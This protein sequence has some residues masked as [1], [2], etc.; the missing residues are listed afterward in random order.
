MAEIAISEMQEGSQEEL[1][2]AVFAAEVPGDPGDARK[3]A[4]LAFEQYLR[5]LDG[6]RGIILWAANKSIDANRIIFDANRLWLSIAPDDGT[7]GSPS[8]G[9]ANFLNIYPSTVTVGANFPPNPYTNDLRLF[10]TA[11]T[12][13]TGAVDTDGT[14]AKTSAQV[15]DLFRYNGT[16]W[17]YISFIG[18]DGVLTRLYLQSDD[19]LIAERS[20]GATLHTSLAHLRHVRLINVT[21]DAGADNYTTETIANHTESYGDN[22]QYEFRAIA[23]NVGAV[24][25]RV[26]Y[27]VG[28]QLLYLGYRTVLDIH[29]LQLM[30]G[31]MQQGELIAVRYDTTIGAWISNIY[32]IADATHPGL[33]SSAQ[34]GKL[35]SA[36]PAFDSLPDASTY[37]VGQV[38][39]VGRRLYKSYNTPD[40]NVIAGTIDVLTGSGFSIRGTRT[41]DNEYGSMGQWTSNPNRVVEWLVVDSTNHIEIAIEQGAYRTAKGSN[42]VDGDQLTLEIT[43]GETTQSAVVSL[44]SGSVDVSDGLT[45]LVFDGTVAADFV[46][47]AADQGDGFELLI[48]QGGSLFVVHDANVRH[49]NVY[50]LS[51][52]LR[53]PST[54]PQRIHT[55][56]RT[57]TDADGNDDDIWIN[58]QNDERA[59]IWEKIE[60]TWLRLTGATK[61]TNEQ[62]RDLVAGFLT[63]GTNVTITHDDANNT[64]TIAATASGGTGGLTAE[65][66]RDLVAGFITAGTNVTVTHDDPS[67]TFTI[68]LDSPQLPALPDAGS[69]DNKIPKFD[70]D[71]LGWEE[72]A[73]ASGG[74][75]TA[76]APYAIMSINAGTTVGAESATPI[77]VPFALSAAR[78]H[79]ATGIIARDTAQATQIVLEPGTYEI[80]NHIIVD[81]TA[82]ATSNPRSNYTVQLYDG[83]TVLDEKDSIGYV[84]AIADVDNESFDSHH[85]L[86]LTAQTSIQ[87]RIGVSEAG[88]TFTSA[89]TATGGTV[90]IR[91]IGSAVPLQL[92]GVKNAQTEDPTGSL[93]FGADFNGNAYVSEIKR[94]EGTPAEGAWTQ[95]THTNYLGAYARFPYLQAPASGRGKYF[96]SKN[97]H[98]FYVSASSGYL[99]YITWNDADVTDVFGNSAI[100]LGEFS[101]EAD[102][103]RAVKNFS[104]SN[105]YYAYF[106]DHVRVLTNAGYT[107]SVSPTETYV[108][109]RV[110]AEE[111]KQLAEVELKLDA[112]IDSFLKGPSSPIVT[113]NEIEFVTE[114]SDPTA[115]STHNYEY[116]TI[117]N[118]G[119]IPGLYRR[120]TIADN[121]TLRFKVGHNGDS[122]GFS[123]G[124]LLGNEYPDFGTVLANIGGSPIAAY[125]WLNTETFG[126]VTGMLIKESAMDALITRILAARFA[127]GDTYVTQNIYSNGALPDDYD[128]S[129]IHGIYLGGVT[130]RLT[131]PDGTS[132]S[133]DLIYSGITEEIDGHRFRMYYRVGGSDFFASH[134]SDDYV[135]IRIRSD[136][137]VE[138]QF[139]GGIGINVGTG[140]DLITGTKGWTG[141]DL[142]HPTSRAMAGGLFTLQQ[143]AVRSDSVHNI[144]VLTQAEYTALAT[145]DAGTVYMIVG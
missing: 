69:R 95:A 38:V 143:K 110:G 5:T 124:N 76:D 117:E 32:P 9:N 54:E 137:D 45:Y 20:V 134:A 99:D 55:E 8:S 85:I 64:L 14:T 52:D 86:T 39:I 131:E 44:V 107:A 4:I 1:E 135:D 87:V 23:T 70:G 27:T 72:D 112:H 140:L 128:F 94:T 36:V 88:A 142:Y 97:H 67:N 59:E 116:L 100:W 127:A 25:L 33:M 57:P 63:A 82:A 37:P 56:S 108:W 83:T 80:T 58:V 101:T 130:V 73:G 126:R 129:G 18:S 139:Q 122:W 77:A 98:D 133:V 121:N 60:G 92:S 103:L 49:W 113:Q 79:N 29:G 62:I 26:S 71:I 41:G 21:A 66:V 75:P 2:T 65:Q 31:A 144:V 111:S 132:A 24:H 28:G 114:L 34:F 105:A 84:R 53:E 7:N 78:S 30:P 136:V 96:Y 51:G 50:S 118:G 93:Q 22:D 13:L 19:T 91:L 123:E 74:D 15:L 138:G 120:D 10:D 16:A 106:D 119:N 17:Q 47:Q 48:Q 46:L 68:S 89:A 81:A 35:T 40:A 61:V 102:A 12:S 3:F 104:N 90:S 6:G 125:A 109:H 115:A 141:V 43:V 145:K 42:E 11:V